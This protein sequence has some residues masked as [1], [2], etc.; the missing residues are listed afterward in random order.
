M[1]EEGNS[2]LAE[3]LIKRLESVGMRTSYRELYD[4]LQSKTTNSRPVGLVF[5]RRK[6][7]SDE[8]PPYPPVGRSLN[9][10]WVIPPRSPSRSSSARSYG[11]TDEFDWSTRYLQGLSIKCRECEFERRAPMRT[12]AAGEG[13]GARNRR[14]FLT[15][16]EEA[17]DVLPFMPRP[18]VDPT[19]GSGLVS[20]ALR[21]IESVV[22]CS[23]DL[24]IMRCI[25]STF[26]GGRPDGADG[27]LESGSEARRQEAEFL[28]NRVL[29]SLVEQAVGLVFVRRVRVSGDE[30]DGRG[31]VLTG[32]AFAVVRKDDGSWSAPCFLSIL[33]SEDDFSRGADMAVS[34]SSSVESDI[35]VVVVRNR[36][37]VSALIEG[38]PVNFTVKA[39]ERANAL[40]RDAAVIE[41]NDGRFRLL[42]SEFVLSVRVNDS[43]NQGAYYLSTDVVE[44]SDIL[45]GE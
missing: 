40:V 34:S 11:I 22:G 35:K 42:D 6:K 12:A 23:D 37:S 32:T 13:E 33:T 4:I 10:T 20:D 41:L 2:F 1:T 31:D 28:S 44:A 18:N 17:R 43:Q 30:A 9:G 26:V 36:V 38:L 8:V 7:R 25:D 29:G 27:T 16:D 15:D 3:K 21:L 24:P 19:G 5:R 14:T 39:N 45:T